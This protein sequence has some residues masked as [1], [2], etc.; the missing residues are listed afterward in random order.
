MDNIRGASLMVLA[1]LGFALEDMFIKLLADAI[2]VGQILAMLGLGGSIIFGAVVLLQGRP[3]FSANMIALPIALRAVGEMVGTICFVSA[4][5]LTPLSSASAILQAT[6]LVVTLGAALFLGEP[7]GWRRWS[8]IMTG[9]VGVLVI[10]RPGLEN[11]QVL[12]L[13]AVAAVFCLAL[14]DLATRRTP[15]E[16]S[17][18]QLSFLGFLVIVPAGLLLMGAQGTPMVIL[19]GWDWVYI[20]TALGIG[21]CAYY[22]IVAAMRVGEVSF[23]TPFRYTRLLFALIAGVFVFGERPDALTLIGAA[24]IVASGIYTVW[25]ERRIGVIP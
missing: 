14:R 17:T 23:V 11:F 1:M 6:P 13:L 2:S 3:L 20:C 21:V 16:I 9:L 5:V 25:R 7:V 24:V 22:A 19:R 18:M 10:I 12:S 8:A 4:I 15:A